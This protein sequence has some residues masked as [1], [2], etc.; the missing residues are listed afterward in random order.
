M[1]LDTPTRPQLISCHVTFSAFLSSK[2]KNWKSK[3]LQ[4]PNDTLGSEKL[5]WW[6]KQR[7]ICYR[8]HDELMTAVVAVYVTKL[9]PTL[10][11]LGLKHTR[12]PCPS[13][14]PRVSSNS[15]PLSWWGY[16]T[17]S[18]HPLPHYGP[19]GMDF[20]VFV[21]D[22]HLWSTQTWVERDP[23]EISFFF[24]WSPLDSLG[25]LG[26]QASQS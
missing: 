8:C 11:P 16:P 20:C 10:Q 19:G 13:L 21:G 15:C 6:K 14:S 17:I 7:Y 5:R 22:W 12:L 9:C 1:S 4:E 2:Q 25:L 3:G 26:D 24:L 23:F 18:S